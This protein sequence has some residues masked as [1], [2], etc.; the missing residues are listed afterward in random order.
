MGKLSNLESS[1]KASTIVG[2]KKEKIMY[3]KLFSTGPHNEIKRM[4]REASIDFVDA[5]A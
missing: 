4:P 1:L 3:R 2:L 5:K